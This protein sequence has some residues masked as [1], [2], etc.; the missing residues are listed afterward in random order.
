MKCTHGCIV[1]A[2]RNRVVTIWL[3]ASH[4][5]ALQLRGPLPA[6]LCTMGRKDLLASWIDVQ[7]EKSL[8]VLHL[9]TTWNK[10]CRKRTKTKGDS[11]VIISSNASYRPA[12]SRYESR[13]RQSTSCPPDEESHRSPKGAEAPHTRS[14]KLP[15][16][17]PRALGR[18]CPDSAWK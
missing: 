15:C 9:P 6:E 3:P 17:R 16:T 11:L 13:V 7:G 8:L 5:W 4:P 12:A 1:F 14:L 2:R 18:R 10:S